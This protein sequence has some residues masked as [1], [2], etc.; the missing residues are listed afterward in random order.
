MSAR[1]KGA[2]RCIV[3]NGINPARPDI[4]IRG[5]TTINTRFRDDRRYFYLSRR[6]FPISWGGYQTRG[7]NGREMAYGKS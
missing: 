1:H 2:I 7:E 3:A 5:W 4:H 6:I